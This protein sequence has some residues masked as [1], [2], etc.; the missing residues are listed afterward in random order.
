MLKSINLFYN[1]KISNLE[2]DNTSCEQ[3]QEQ[4]RQELCPHSNNSSRCFPMAMQIYL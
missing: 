1:C 2:V 3:E 4:E